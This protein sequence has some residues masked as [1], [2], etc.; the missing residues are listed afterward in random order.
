VAD[1]RAIPAAVFTDP[2]MASVGTTNGDQVVTGVHMIAGGRLSTY[3]RPERPGLLDLA[4]G[5]KERVIV[6][7]LAMGPAAGEWIGQ[8]TLAVRARMPIEILPA[9]L[10]PPQGLEERLCESG[11]AALR[12]TTERA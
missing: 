10:S 6:G 12:A 4:A 1:Y 8:L 7:A 11:R 3:E 5:T 9:T 2:Q